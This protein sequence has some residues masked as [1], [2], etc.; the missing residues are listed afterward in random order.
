MAHQANLVDHVAGNWL[1]GFFACAQ[2]LS[3]G[4]GFPCEGDTID[5]LSNSHLPLPYEET[6]VWV[7]LCRVTGSSGE[8][9]QSPVLRGAHWWSQP[10]LVVILA[11][12]WKWFSY[13]HVI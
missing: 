13:G 8:V 2:V 6:P 10:V 1:G 11:S 9:G 5:C 7:T 3:D 4:A 12:L